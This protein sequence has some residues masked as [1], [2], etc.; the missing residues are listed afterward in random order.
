MNIAAGFDTGF[1][2]YYS[3]D[4][5]LNSGNPGSVTVWSGLNGTGTLLAALTLLDTGNN[6]N[7]PAHYNM[8]DAAGISFAGTAQSAIFSG[9][10]NYIGFDNITLGSDTPLPAVPEPSTCLAAAL[11]LLPFGASLIR[12]LRKA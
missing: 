7:Y 2:F 11:L 8:W 9:A 1:S 5:Q 10:A 4:S 3:S 6:G 12:K